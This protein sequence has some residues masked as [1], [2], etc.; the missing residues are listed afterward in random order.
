MIITEGNAKEKRT[1]QISAGALAKFTVYSS[2]V[3]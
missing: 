3:R 1:G 2:F